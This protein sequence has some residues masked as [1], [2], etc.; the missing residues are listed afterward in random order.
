MLT[1][2]FLILNA[3]VLAPTLALAQERV[4]NLDQTDQEAYLVFGVPETDDVGVSFWCA[5]QSGT[6]KFYVPETD[7]GLKLSDG[8]KFELDIAAKTYPLEGKASANEEAGSISLETELK[9]ADPIFSA[10]EAAD[11]F[12]VDVGASKHV[13]P[14]A[15]ADFPGLLDV[16]KI[17]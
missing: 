12:A 11:Y 14:L 1:R 15:E 2:L 13:F 16:C 8:V 3:I 17:P 4:W 7:P 6:V 10:L 9:T 5:L